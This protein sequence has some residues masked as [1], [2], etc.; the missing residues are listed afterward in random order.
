MVLRLRQSV[1][2]NRIKICLQKYQ[3]F[4]S[5]LQLSPLPIGA[6]R[7]NVD[8]IFSTPGG[9]LR[10]ALASRSPAAPPSSQHQHMHNLCLLPIPAVAAQR[11]QPRL[12]SYTAYDKNDIKI[13]LTLQT[14]AA[15]PG[16]VT[17]S[18]ESLPSI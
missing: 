10:S 9:N 6:Q 7:S 14:S 11:A 17:I 12:I 4:R 5:S 18:F 15:R 3:K 16:V 13:T 1:P 2:Y 8:D